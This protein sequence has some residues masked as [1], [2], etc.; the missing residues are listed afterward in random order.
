MKSDTA[1]QFKKLIQQGAPANGAPV[2]IS[3]KILANT[4]KIG[5]LANKIISYLENIINNQ[6]ILN[7]KLDA[8]L[9]NT[10]NK[11]NIIYVDKMS[12]RQLY[13]CYK[14][15]YTLDQISLVSGY[16]IDTIQQRIA[17][18]MRDNT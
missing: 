9:N 7:D 14:R 8:L 15:G 5:N 12:A 11:N 13:M 16:D 4:I 6:R 2:S 10:S 17:I 1:E 18:Y 3:E